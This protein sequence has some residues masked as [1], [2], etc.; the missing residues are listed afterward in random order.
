MRGTHRGIPV[1]NMGS[2]AVTRRDRAP[3]KAC[4]VQKRAAGQED[5]GLGCGC[6]RIGQQVPLAIVT[7]VATE[8]RAAIM[9][10][11]KGAKLT[12]EPCGVGEDRRQE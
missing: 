4:P 2:M 10:G 3:E 1:S 9:S 12:T 8:G 5:E 11:H 6:G 7:G